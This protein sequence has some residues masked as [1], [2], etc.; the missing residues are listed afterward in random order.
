MLK[1]NNTNHLNLLSKL[2]GIIPR[3]L[4]TVDIEETKSYQL[5]RYT[6][7]CFDISP[8]TIVSIVPPIYTNAMP[9]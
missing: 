7:M 4:I 1:K 3:N 8:S 5:I 9:L 2:N 6:E